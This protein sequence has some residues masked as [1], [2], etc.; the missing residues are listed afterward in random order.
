MGIE[1]EAV[2]EDLPSGFDGLRAE[3]RA[4]GFRQVERLATDWEART[5]RFDR[6]GEALLA[7]YS[8]A[9]VVS[10][11]SPSSRAPFACGASTCGQPSG[12][13]ASVV[14]W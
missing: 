10:R 12:G 3:A 13:A 14:S 7:A 6:D 1:I 4:E 2:V 5:I 9:L 8:P 11:W